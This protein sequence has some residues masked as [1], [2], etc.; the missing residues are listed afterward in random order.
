MEINNP[1]RIA[2][3]NSIRTEAAL[4]GYELIYLDARSST[5]Q[6]VQDVRSLIAQKVDYIVLAPREYEALAPALADARAAGIPL[7]LVDRAARGEPG[8]D[9]LTLI[10]SDFVEEGERAGLWL[11]AATQGRASI[12]EL[13]GT[14][15][16]SPTTGRKEGFAKAIARFP[17]MRIIDSESAG[18]ER[19]VGQE[20][21]EGM[22]KVH[23]GEITAVYAHND[24]M[25]IGAIQ[26]L[27]AAGLVPGRDVILVS[28]DGER[29]ALKAIIA[30]E[31]GA[32][33][34]CNPRLGPKI[35]DVIDAYRRGESIPPTIVVPDRMFDRHNASRYFDEAY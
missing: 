12:I 7:I 22:I 35:F 19:T 24:E 29:D 26:A 5:T 33:V 9:Y 15:D 21:M 25:A 31:L 14:L 23:H 30:N 13:Q 6:Q 34:E 10:A 3:T 20:V 1:W 2:E 16:A 18:F 17:G 27:K 8:R 28:A 4:R 32:S 11:A